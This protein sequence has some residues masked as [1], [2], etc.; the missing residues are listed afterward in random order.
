MST[1]LEQ[2][3]HG[4]GRR[5][6][7]CCSALVLLVVGLIVMGPRPAE[8]QLD[9]LVLEGVSVLSDSILIR[10]L[11]LSSYDFFDSPRVNVKGEIYNGTGYFI[12]FVD[13]TFFHKD[14]TG[15]IISR[16]FAR[17]QGE[18]II[19]LSVVTVDAIAPG[20]TG[21]LDSEF[22]RESD[23]PLE[24]LVSYSISIDFDTQSEHIP[25]DIDRDGDVDFDD[26]F[27]L[28]DNFGRRVEV[29]GAGKAAPSEEIDLAEAEL[30]YLRDRIRKAE[31]RTLEAR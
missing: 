28:A 26:F 3:V 21:F 9:S 31:G 30:I 6:N 17:A 16:S 27:A 8:T 19:D 18:T 4:S 11:E 24:D 20:A 10:G 15:S 5:A 7:R 22:Y 13:L 23:Y 2:R 12:Y 1:N 29:E 25:G 14:S